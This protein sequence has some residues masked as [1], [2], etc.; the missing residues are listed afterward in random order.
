ML[1]NAVY[2]T[3]SVGVGFPFPSFQSTVLLPQQLFPAA[4]RGEATLTQGKQFCNWV[5]FS[6][7]SL[8]F[9]TQVY[10]FVVS[11]ACTV[12]DCTG[13]T[14]SYCKGFPPPE[15]NP[16]FQI[17]WSIKFLLKKRC[18]PR[19]VLCSVKQWL[20]AIESKNH[21]LEREQKLI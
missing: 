11:L 7:A 20:L 10:V 12:A 1:N 17:C 16:S 8:L 2:I 14:E 15:V 18:S 21:W 4:T 6:S 19:M 9:L 5:F 3:L 13:N